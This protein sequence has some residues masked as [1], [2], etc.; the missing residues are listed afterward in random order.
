MYKVELTNNKILIGI[1]STIDV[2]NRVF[3]IL[4]QHDIGMIGRDGQE[5][6]FDDCLGVYKNSRNTR[7]H[8]IFDSENAIYEWIRNYKR[9]G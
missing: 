3:K 6:K 1:I 7:D 2:P 8:T 5:I 9:E 4:T